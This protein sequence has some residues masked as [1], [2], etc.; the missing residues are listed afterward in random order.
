MCTCTGTP[1]FP[2]V[3]II[4][5]RHNDNYIDATLGWSR[6]DYV[7]Y[8]LTVSPDV[9]TRFSDLNVAHLTLFYDVQFNVHVT[10]NLCG[11]NTTSTEIF[12]FSKLFKV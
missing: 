3:R 6:E 11:R 12:F 7:T 2:Q 4:S 1:N 8:S 5:E 9:A 10:A